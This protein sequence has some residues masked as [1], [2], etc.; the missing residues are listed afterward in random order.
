MVEPVPDTDE[1]CTA[2]L[3]AIVPGN[4]KRIGQVLSRVGDK[5]SILIIMLLT[6]GPQRFSQIKRSVDGISQR[7]LT[8]CLRG[9]ERDGLVKR[10]VYEVVPAHVEYELTSLGYSLTMPVAG[11]GRWAMQNLDEIEKARDRFDNRNTSSEK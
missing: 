3:T 6:N 11:L 8:L 4:C 2:E 1:R 5:W 9:L 10:T 7:M